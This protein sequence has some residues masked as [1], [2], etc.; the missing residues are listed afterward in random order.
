MFLKKQAE[1]EMD[2]VAKAVLASEGSDIES[3]VLHATQETSAHAYTS[4]LV[5]LIEYLAG[6]LVAFSG[7]R[8]TSNNAGLAPKTFENHFE[9]EMAG[10]QAFE[11]DIAHLAGPNIE[12]LS[13]NAD[14]ELLHEAFKV[15]TAFLFLYS[16]NVAH[17]HLQ[18]ENAREFSVAL[19]RCV[20][21]RCAGR[22]GFS[23]EP[24]QAA[25]A[26]EQLIPSLCCEKLL[27]LEAFGQ[28]DGLG[29]LL[30]HLNTSLRGPNEYGFVVG[31]RNQPLGCATPM[32][33]ALKEIE[34]SGKTLARALC[35]KPSQ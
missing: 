4:R 30:D 17:K 7:R 1:F 19:F 3:A 13:R 25:A 20:A 16:Q 6:A 18:P 32:V 8:V 10:F 12:D 21:E 9:L 24:H 23:L 31:S 14:P 11:T 27:N 26:L 29:R 34:D 22:F 5:G 2:D 28:G 15:A 33:K 35:G